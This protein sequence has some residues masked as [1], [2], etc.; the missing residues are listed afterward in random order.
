MPRRREGRDLPEIV[1]RL[2]AEAR[3]QFP[4]PRAV[5]RTLL[6]LSRF[7]DPVSGGVILEHATRRRIVELLENGQTEEASR[8]L[9]ERFEEYSRSFKPGGEK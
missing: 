4:D 7:Y 5:N 9:E 6:E 8:A 3:A 2:F 1:M